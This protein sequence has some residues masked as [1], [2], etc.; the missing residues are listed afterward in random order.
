MVIR[1]NG[2]A[3]LFGTTVRG[4]PTTGTSMTDTS[5]DARFDPA[6]AGPAVPELDL[7]K[8]S[9]AN[10]PGTSNVKITIDVT[11]LDVL[12]HALD[13]TGAAAV[14]YVAR[15]IGPAVN[16]PNTGTKNPVYYASVE[17]QP[18]GV[19]TFFAGA[20][21][22]VDL[23][24]VS[25][26]TPHIINYPA[27]PQGGTLVTGVLKLG[28]KQNAVDQWIITVPRSVIG[29]PPVGSLFESLSAFTL[30]R[31]HTAGLTLTQTEGEAG[32]TPIEVDGV[33][34]RDATI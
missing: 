19:A 26:C 21:Q 8:V 5:G 27:P 7:R 29:N 1:Q 25:A 15:W 23:C 14:E 32:I 33:C 16:D 13:A 28:T 3:G 11:S 4:D 12:Q 34:C 9:I 24:S 10:V 31:N 22:S 30:A 20:A 6:Y 18:G 2:G 17:V